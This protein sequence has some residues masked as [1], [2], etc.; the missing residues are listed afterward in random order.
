MVQVLIDVLECINT[1][2]PKII[3]KRVQVIF[4]IW[5]NFYQMTMRH[6]EKGNSVVLKIS[7]AAEKV[8]VRMLI[9]ND[10]LRKSNL[11]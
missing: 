6:K 11:N 10:I 4:N 3:T 9:Q 7:I 8:A 2:S 5:M 1:A